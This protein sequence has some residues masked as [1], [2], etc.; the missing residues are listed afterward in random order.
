MIGTGR[1]KFLAEME[2]LTVSLVRLDALDMHT[3]ADLGVSTLGSGQKLN[4]WHG[5]YGVVFGNWQKVR[6]SP[7]TAD[8]KM[9]I[10]RFLVLVHLTCIRDTLF[11][12][13]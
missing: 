2:N 7:P 11:N 13:G 6:V 1:R 3:A 10:N 12:M 4:A 5:V 9:G 8:Q